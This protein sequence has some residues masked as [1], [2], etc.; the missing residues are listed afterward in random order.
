[1]VEAVVREIPLGKCHYED[2]SKRIEF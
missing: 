2:L 1:L